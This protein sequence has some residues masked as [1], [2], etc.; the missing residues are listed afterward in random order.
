VFTAH[1]TRQSCGQNL[2]IVFLANLTFLREIFCKMAVLHLFL[3]LASVMHLTGAFEL[4]AKYDASNFFAADSFHFHKGND[5]TT[6]RLAEYVSKDEA[7]RLKLTNT[8]GA[9]VF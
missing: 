2:A 1:G 4:K 9:E 3:G 5:A 8:D 7:M 6:H